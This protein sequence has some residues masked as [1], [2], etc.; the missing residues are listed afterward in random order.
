MDF[1]F[2]LPIYSYGN[3]GI[4]VFVDCFIKMS[5]LAAVLNSIYR[6]GTARLSFD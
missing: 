1:G 2:G 4:V 6:G 3:T 5:Y